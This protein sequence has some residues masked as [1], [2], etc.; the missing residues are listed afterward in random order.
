MSE[1]GQT[2]DIGLEDVL[3]AERDA[4]QEE[5]H[6]AIP[7]RVERYDAA[8]QVADVTP[9]VRRSLPRRDGSRAS[10]A[11]PTIRSVPVIFPCS[12]DF[13]VRFPVKADDEG[14]LLVCER[15]LA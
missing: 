3:A 5:L 6:P 7:G 9:M 13:F 8:K 14:L 11:I 12:G 2:D 4:Q 10:V 15:D 1:L